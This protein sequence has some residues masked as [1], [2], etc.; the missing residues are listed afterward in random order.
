MTTLKQKELVCHGTSKVNDPK[1]NVSNHGRRL[2]DTII[3][4]LATEDQNNE[5]GEPKTIFFQWGTIFVLVLDG[6]TEPPILTMFG[7]NVALL[8]TV[9]SEEDNHDDRMPYERGNYDDRRRYGVSQD[10]QRRNDDVG[11][12]DRDGYNRGGPQQGTN[13]GDGHQNGDGGSGGGRRY[14]GSGGGRRY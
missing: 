2:I 12:H 7:F 14:H 8:V 1:I 10:H 13:Y 5:E 4:L 9:R 3:N 11:S 6:H